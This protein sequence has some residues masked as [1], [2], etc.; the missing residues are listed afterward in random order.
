MSATSR[1]PDPGS[2]SH[3]S[4]SVAEKPLGGEM[5]MLLENLLPAVA[6][7]NPGMTSTKVCPSYD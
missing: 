1:V 7:Y 4:S 6:E 3:H 5:L 2:S